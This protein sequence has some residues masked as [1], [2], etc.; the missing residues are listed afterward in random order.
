M[1]LS[2]ASDG[3]IPEIKT[4]LKKKIRRQTMCVLEGVFY[5]EGGWQM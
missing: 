4:F 1:R 2:K 3:C 5:G